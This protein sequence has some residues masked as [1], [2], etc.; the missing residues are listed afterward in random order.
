VE[1]GGGGGDGAGSVGEDGLVVGLIVR[2]VLATTNV[3]RDRDMPDAGKEFVR[4]R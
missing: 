3:G 1:A 4:R 2:A